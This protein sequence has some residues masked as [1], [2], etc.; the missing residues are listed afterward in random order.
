MHASWCEHY[1]LKV[2]NQLQLDLDTDA[3][4]V[5]G[6]QLGVLRREMIHWRN[7]QIDPAETACLKAIILFN[8][9]MHFLEVAN[10]NFR[11]FLLWFCCCC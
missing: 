1:T 3:V 4:D 9:D 7:L 6:E 11:S 2:V 10:C 5:A 8:L